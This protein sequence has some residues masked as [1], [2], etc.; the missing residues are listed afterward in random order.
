MH[1]ICENPILIHRETPI[2]EC[3]PHCACS[4]ACL[5]RSFQRINLSLSENVYI[6][7]IDVMQGYGVFAKKEF[8]ANQLIGEYEGESISIDEAKRR[9]KESVQQH[10]MQNYILCVTEHFGTHTMTTVCPW[11]YPMWIVMNE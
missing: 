6:E 7:Y 5:N 4:K 11:F 8:Q 9:W 2:V 10:D 3:N 1:D